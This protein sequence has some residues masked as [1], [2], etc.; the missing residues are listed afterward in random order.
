MPQNTYIYEEICEFGV[1]IRKSKAY[2]GGLAAEHLYLR[3]KV[4]SQSLASPES[5]R[6]FGV[7][8]GSDAKRILRILLTAAE[9]FGMFEIGVVE[10]RATASGLLIAG[11]WKL[12]AACWKLE[13]GSWC[14]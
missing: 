9:V 13:A 11:G 4:A 14:C 2:L 1:F 3:R 7:G 5:W 6:S 8:L 12:L 10:P